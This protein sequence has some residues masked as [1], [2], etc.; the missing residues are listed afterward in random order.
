MIALRPKE[1]AKLST[2]TNIPQESL[3]LLHSL[4]VL[5][6]SMVID[7]LVKFEYTKIKKTQKYKSKHIIAALSKE[8]QITE[9]KVK[10]AIYN[11]KEPPHHCRICGK[12]ITKN[13]YSMHDALCEDCVVDTIIL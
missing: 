3:Q 11:K 1:L 13:R 4:H 12:P 10:N 5:E 9:S 2:I 8:Y 7:L 6:E